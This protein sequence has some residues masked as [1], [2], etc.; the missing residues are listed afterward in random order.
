MTSSPRKRILILGGYGE[1][2]Y[3]LASL[4]GK[5]LSCHI[6]LAGRS[7]EKGRDRAARLQALPGNRAD[8]DT[9]VVD[10]SEAETAAD[11]PKGYDLLMVACPLSDSGLSALIEGCIRYGTDF[12]DLVP[13]AAKARVF[14]EWADAIR[15]GT[16]RFVLDAG[17]IPGLPGWLVRDVTSEHPDADTLRLWGRYRSDRIGWDGVGDILD[18]SDNQGWRY[19]RKW[20]KAPWWD[21]RMRRFPG[22]LGRGVCVP[23]YLQELSELPEQ[24]GLERFS[25]YH[26]GLNPATDALMTLER[27]AMLSM[28]RPVTR[29]SLFFHAMRRFS[30]PPFGLALVAELEQ[31]GEILEIELWH[32]DLYQAT[33]VP[34]ALMAGMLLRA[35]TLYP[36]YGHLGFWATQHPD[37]SG[38]LES[39]G[40]HFNEKRGK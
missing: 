16:S 25:F 21:V 29:Q 8:F 13:M 22:G 14:S 30:R 3:R 10:L 32:R 33:A 39:Y 37:F 4:I 28:V 27:L 20:R 12:I 2:G 9:L 19:Q 24:L 36:N 26:A 38:A 31:G 7:L 18:E 35:P 11:C 23:I 6:T 17:A 40:F 15:T 1:A 5:E 34:A